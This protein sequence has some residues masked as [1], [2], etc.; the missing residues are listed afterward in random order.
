MET[1]QPEQDHFPSFEQQYKKQENIKSIVGSID[2]VDIVP[3][4]ISNPTPILLI[5]GWSENVSTYKKSLKTIYDEK[6]RVVTVGK[7]D[8]EGKYGKWDSLEAE[9]TKAQLILDALDHKDLN[10]V[11]TIA[12]SEGAIITL[13]AAVL[14]PE[15]FRNIVLDKPAGFIGS[16]TKTQLM[17][18]FVK[19]MI[20]EAVLR[21]KSL[22]DPTGA[23]Q[24]GF[25]TARYCVE[26]P[27]RVLQEMDALTSYDISDLMSLLRDKGVMVSVI[28]GVDDPLF[29]VSRQVENMRQAGA[30]PI[31]GY[32]SVIGGHNELSIHP[33]K[34]TALAVNA[35]DSLQ[36][37]REDSKQ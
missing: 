35:L 18:R 11:D 16:D 14:E 22:S 27:Q 19:L 15:R 8:K 36:R 23:V 24:A 10:R 37:K 25:R 17:G 6:R 3:Q 29:L 31:E 20:Q 5:P 26:N 33:E 21:P 4:E 13:L 28:S 12:H 9:M 32:Y 7:Y 30:P 2:I 1:I 34:H